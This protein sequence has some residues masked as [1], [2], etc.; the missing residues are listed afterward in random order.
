M[1]HAGR[2]LHTES[3]A[4]P[5]YVLDSGPFLLTAHHQWD[6]PPTR[7]EGSEGVDNIYATAPDLD[8]GDGQRPQVTEEVVDRICSCCPAVVGE[9][10]ELELDDG[11]HTGIDQV[12]ELTLPEQLT[13]QFSIEGQGSCAA[14][15]Q[16]RIAL[17]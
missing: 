13:E 14:L 4:K 7:F 15:S 11:D 9:V 8:V 2:R 5:G 17:V 12:P 10:L 1:G 16:G 6:H 3:I